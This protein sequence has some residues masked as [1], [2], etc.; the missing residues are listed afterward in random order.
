MDRIEIEGGVPLKGQIRI[1][2]AKNACLAQLPATLLTGESVT[3]SNV[4]ELA[5]VVSMSELLR[6]LGAGVI[7]D[8]GRSE[9][10]A[11]A[12]EISN[13]CAHYDIVRKMRASFLVLGPLLVREG[14]GAGVASRRLRN[15]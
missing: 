13:C 1:G 6:S 15:W 5:D 11:T 14:R 7:W 8:R 12:T 10:T 9:I 2:G 4:P 3:L